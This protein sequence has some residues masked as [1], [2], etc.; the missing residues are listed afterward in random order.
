MCGVNLKNVLSCL[1]CVCVCWILVRLSLGACVLGKTESYCAVSELAQSGLGCMVCSGRRPVCDYKRRSNLVLLS[2]F[3]WRILTETLV[4]LL[5]T[6]YWR[7]TRLSVWQWSWLC[8]R[9]WRGACKKS[10]GRSVKGI[11]IKLILDDTATGWAY[12]DLLNRKGAQLGTTDGLGRLISNEHRMSW[13]REGSQTWRKNTT[14]SASHRTIL[15]G[16]S[17][18]LDCLGD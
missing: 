13:N 1:K 16:Y 10:V 8:T 4:Y 14:P 3:Y 6:R 9:A 15:G 11:H 17:V 7:Y 5:D 12:L 18:S 2:S